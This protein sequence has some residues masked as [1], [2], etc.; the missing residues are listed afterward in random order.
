MKAIISIL[1]TFIIINHLNAQ[2]ITVG[3]TGKIIKN[4]K[5]IKNNDEITLSKPFPKNINKTFFEQEEIKFLSSNAEFRIKKINGKIYRDPE[6][7]TWNQFRLDGKKYSKGVN[8]ASR[9]IEESFTYNC[10]STKNISDQQYS[11][12][13]LSSNKTKIFNGI[14]CLTQ[15]FNDD[16][17]WINSTDTLKF[18]FNSIDR[19]VFSGK[20]KIEFKA[21]DNQVII[22][23]ELLTEEYYTIFI[24]DK[25]NKIVMEKYVKF[26]YT[27]KEIKFYKNQLKYDKGTVGE[28]FVKNYL[29]KDFLKSNEKIQSPIFTN[30]MENIRECIK[31]VYENKD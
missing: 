9:G 25:N 10:D 3:I 17:Y 22:N 14:D 31:L 16:I 8:C 26:I 1:F 11:L 27:N 19:I 7:S 20:D 18:N 5:P 12:L 2:K 4:S 15:Y 30:I 24:F 6:N 28:I 23:P 13:S 29:D 21:I